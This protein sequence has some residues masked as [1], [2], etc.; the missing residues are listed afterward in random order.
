MPFNL[1][2]GSFQLIDLRFKLS[3]V[4][5]GLCSGGVPDDPWVS[6][7]L[8]DGSP[9]GRFKEILWNVLRSAT[10]PTVFGLGTVA[11]VVFAGPAY[12]RPFPADPANGETCQQKII[13][14]AMS[15]ASPLVS[16]VLHPTRR[17]LILVERILP[18]GSTV[19]A[20]L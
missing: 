10:Y 19:Q 20:V 17:G 4:K 18:H 7:H 5:R 8:S 9:N 2:D 6:N 16:Y 13:F 14:R 1:G 12:N 15:K 11:P 3:G